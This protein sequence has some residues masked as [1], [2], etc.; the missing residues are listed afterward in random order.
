MYDYSNI[1]DK[2]PLVGYTHLCFNY[3]LENLARLY[4]EDLP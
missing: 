3:I 2:A 1:D 4:R